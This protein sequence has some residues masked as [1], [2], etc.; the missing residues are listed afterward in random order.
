MV[1]T[2]KKLA[3]TD[4]SGFIRS[5]HLDPGNPFHQC[6]NTARKRKNR[7]APVTGPYATTASSKTALRELS[8][9]MKKGQ[10]WECGFL[11]HCPSNLAVH[12]FLATLFRLSTPMNCTINVALK[13]HCTIRPSYR[14]SRCHFCNATRFC[15]AKGSWWQTAGS[16]VWWSIFSTVWDGLRSSWHSSDTWKHQEHWVMIGSIT[17]RAKKISSSMSRYHNHY[18][19]HHQGYHSRHHH[20]QQQQAK[21]KTTKKLAWGVGALNKATNLVNDTHR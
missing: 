20:Q 6:A 10:K 16:E 1:L 19:P 14:H 17:T 21:P 18:S 2:P 5:R 9:N 4:A 8:V 15:P 11:S 13:M 12:S 3:L 7:L